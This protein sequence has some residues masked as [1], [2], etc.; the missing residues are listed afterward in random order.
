MGGG[1]GGVGRRGRGLYLGS[2]MFEGRAD[3]ASDTLY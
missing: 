2:A 3:R 1:A